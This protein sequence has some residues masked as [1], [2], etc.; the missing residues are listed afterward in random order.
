M[1]R[2]LYDP[3]HPDHAKPYVRDYIRRYGARKVEQNIKLIL[4]R[5]LT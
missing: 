5:E 4:T 3:R 1:A 2:R